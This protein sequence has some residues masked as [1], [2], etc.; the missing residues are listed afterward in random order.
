[1]QSSTWRGK[2]ASTESDGLDMLTNSQAIG[3]RVP[4]NLKCC[5]AGSGRRTNVPIEQNHLACLEVDASYIL[6]KRRGFHT[7]PCRP[8][9]TP[10]SPL[11]LHLSGK[12]KGADA[13]CTIVHS[14]VRDLAEYTQRA[15]IAVSGVGRQ[16]T[17]NADRVCTG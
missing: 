13:A 8:G 3:L 15:D 4:R 12:G 7:Y 11:S 9:P 16:V 1:M 5:L 17:V 2:E 6:D 10:G 14:A